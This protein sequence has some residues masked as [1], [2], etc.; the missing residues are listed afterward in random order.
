[1]TVPLFFFS[2]RLK[3]F[4]FFCGLTVLILHSYFSYTCVHQH[5]HFSPVQDFYVIL[6]LSHRSYILF[7][8]KYMHTH[9][10][11]A[12]SEPHQANTKQHT[13]THTKLSPPNFQH[14]TKHTNALFHAGRRWNPLLPPVRGIQRSGLISERQENKVFMTAR[15]RLC[16]R[17]L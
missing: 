6:C 3:V 4:G 12:H 1:M 11:I 17:V 15:E 9:H 16:C 5:N 2:Q 13:P 14:Q 10:T 8:F 7:Y